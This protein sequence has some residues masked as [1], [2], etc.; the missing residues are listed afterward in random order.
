MK[1]QILV[2]SQDC[3]SLRLPKGNRWHTQV[4]IICG[5]FTIIL[6]VGG[7]EP[8]KIVQK[9]GARSI[10]IVTTERGY[11][12]LERESCIEYAALKVVVTF[13]QEKSPP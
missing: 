12:N 10:R 1:M 6:K 4:R 9:L 5:R 8:Q 2:Y 11:C 3:V 7:V 13:Y